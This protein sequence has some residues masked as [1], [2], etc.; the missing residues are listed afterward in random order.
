MFIPNT[1]KA[2]Y[3]SSF[4]WKMMAKSVDMY[5]R[6]S[7]LKNYPL[8]RSQ[9]VYQISKSTET[10]LHNVITCIENATEQKDIALGAFLDI[11]GAFKRTSFDKIKHC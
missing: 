7:A 9:H 2:D 1:R 6:N 10:A 11:E 4:L 3:L 8:H 5:I